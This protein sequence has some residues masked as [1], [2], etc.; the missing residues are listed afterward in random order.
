LRPQDEDS[1]SISVPLHMQSLSLRKIFLYLIVKLL[2]VTQKTLELASSTAQNFDRDGHNGILSD[3][4]QAEENDLTTAL[5]DLRR[6]VE[7]VR[8]PRF[9]GFFDFG[10]DAAGSSNEFYREDGNTLRKDLFEQLLPTLESFTAGECDKQSRYIFKS[11]RSLSSRHRETMFAQQLQS[12]IESLFAP[13]EAM[14]LRV[15]SSTYIFGFE[16]D[17][18]VTDN[19]RPILNVEL[20][21]LHH[22]LRTKKGFCSLRDD[23]LSFRGVYVLRTS[24]RQKINQ[25]DAI[26]MCVRALCG[27]RDKDKTFKSV[28]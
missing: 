20:D 28:V 2:S 5:T 14:Q 21:G 19:D 16:S 10:R 8:L 11:R 27:I 24:T 18:V 23:V 25:D 1:K 7:M 9:Q 3:K 22:L 17:I 15:H 12:R 6:I 4:D 13:A 26:A